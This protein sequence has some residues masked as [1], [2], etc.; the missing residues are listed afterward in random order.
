MKTHKRIVTLLKMSASLQKCWIAPTTV[1]EIDQ[2]W[3]LLESVQRRAM[4]II[5]GLEHLSYEERLRNLCL[6]SL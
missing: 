6:F 4:K 1:R 3:K 5:K 2:N